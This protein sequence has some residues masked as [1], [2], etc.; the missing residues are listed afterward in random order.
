MI[1][2]THK[3]IRF[4]T[5]QQYVAVKNGFLLGSSRRHRS[6]VENMQIREVQSEMRYWS[7]LAGR[8]TWA[9]LREWCRDAL[10]IMIKLSKCHLS[11]RASIRA[12]EHIKELSICWRY[13][14]NWII[15]SSLI[16]GSLACDKTIITKYLQYVQASLCVKVPS[17]QPLLSHICNARM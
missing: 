9:N 12:P 11:S 3:E 2:P 6:Y 13:L 5:K 7:P 8:R 15:I 14:W 1:H 10:H 17:A 16:S 4:E